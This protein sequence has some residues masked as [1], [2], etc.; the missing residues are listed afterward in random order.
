MTEDHF[1]FP[2]GTVLFPGGILPLKIFEQ[3]Y[4]EMTKACLRDSLPFGVCLIR[5]G[6]E[7]GE[8]AVPETVGCLATIERWDMPQLGL[9]Q[10]VARGSDR[11][12]LLD[13]RVAPNGLMSGTIERLGADAPCTDVDP[14]CRDVL[15]LVIEQVGEANFPAPIALDDASW[16]GFRLAEILPFEAREKQALL[17]LQDAGARLARLR[18]LLVKNGLV[19]D[20]SA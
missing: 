19:A 11:F 9:F 3:R 4:I 18:E 1:I 17:E 15:K 16:V 8:P 20:G 14:T 2:L 10:L 6:R 5:E 7:V 13:N 12:R